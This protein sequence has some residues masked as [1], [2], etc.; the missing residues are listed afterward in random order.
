MSKF[1]YL[2]FLL[3]L[4]TNLVNA[5]TTKATLSGTVANE[6]TKEQIENTTIQLLKSDSSYVTGTI[7]NDSGK[8]VIAN[9]D[10]GKY[11]VRISNLGYKTIEQ[12]FT[13]ASKAINLGNI[14]LKA[15]AIML[16][17]ALVTANLPKMVVQADTFI[18][19]ADAYRIPE[20]STIDALVEAL[21]GAQIDENGKITIN[22]K[23]V[24]KI[25]VD[26][27]EFITGDTQT[28]LKNLPSDIVDKVKAFDQ[29]SDLSRMTG[30]DDG[31]D[32]TVLDF[33]IKPKMKKGFFT[34]TKMGYGTD[35]RYGG[36]AMG[37]RMDGDLRYT[38][39]GNANNTND[40]GF[41]GRRG[42]E[43]GGDGLNASKTTAFTVSYEKRDKLKVEGN[44]RWNHRDG[45]NTVQTSVEN[46]VNKTG[47][48]SNSMSQ[49]YSRSDGWNTNLRL[50]WKID[51]MTTI[52]IQPQANINFNDSR[53]SSKSASF[54]QDP[55]TLVNNPLSEDAVSTLEEAGIFVNSRSNKTVSYG[56]SNSLGTSFLFHRRLNSTGRN[57][58][59][60]LNIN[61][62]EGHNKYLSASNVHLYM[63]RNRAGTDS[64]YQTNRYRQTPSYNFGYGFNTSY[65]EPLWKGTFIQLSY[66]FSYNYDKND[67]STYSFTDMTEDEFQ[68]ILNDYRDWDAYFR[69]FTYPLDY[70]LNKDLSR[71]SERT[72]YNHNFNTQ[73]RIVR[74]KYNANIGI[75]V[76]PQK[77]HFIQNYIGLAVDTVRKVVNVSPTFN[78][79]YRF[80]KQRNM[81]LTYH[82]STDQPNITDMLNVVDDTNPLNITIGNPGLKP[83]FTSRMSGEYRDYAQRHQRT[84][85]MNA[86]YSNTQNSFSN[87][88]TY[89]ENTGGRI[90]QPQN[91]NGDW[92]ASSTVMLNTSIDTA[93]VW[94]IN[95]TTGISYNHMVGYI[96]LNKNTASQKNI[97]RMT[98]LNENLSAGFRNSWLEATI[99]GTVHY[100]ISRNMLQERSNLDTWRFSY[101]FSVNATAPWGMSFSTNLHEHSRRGFSDQTMNTN[102]LIW[103]AQISQG[104]LRRKSLTVSLQLN[105]ILAQQSNFSR[106]INANSRSDTEYNMINSYA[107][108]SINYRM[109]FFG[110]RGSRSSMRS[111]EG[112]GPSERFNN[113]GNR[114]GGNFPSGSPRGRRF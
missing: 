73:F 52:N 16:D 63:V 93:G 45:D 53:N 96:T 61:Y 39:I 43:S 15:D 17:E 24:S 49:G 35:K 86:N 105:D 81:R 114:R 107:M 111:S 58:S 14:L 23:A 78:F 55:Y 82:G 106:R 48:F 42:K 21:P 7:T 99:D 5:Q 85:M 9:I 66:D 92:A 94:N 22:G 95:T 112:R 62:G 25:M 100:T 98:S 80:N 8:F 18:Y 110:S 27:R 26:G 4:F 67:Q 109:N 12:P 102:E 113:G 68:S 76:R 57:F 44:V 1:T 88:V 77:S 108:L 51:T 33:T 97:T 36:R 40:R 13:I 38:L 50:E 30:I 46:F 59:F 2:S 29:K 101:G 20:G 70:Y 89:D 75:Q 41:S 65:T 84:F 10:K 69:Y 91:I 79:Q 64:T 32:Q 19:N 6:D 34:N 71:Y 87:R 3:L 72:N 37:S 60:G 56:T 47:A 74:E 11:I 103:N 83:S 90:V 104:F 28:A 54:K 31:N